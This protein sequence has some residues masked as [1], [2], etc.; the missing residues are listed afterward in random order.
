MNDKNYFLEKK[1]TSHY[2]GESKIL[3]SYVLVCSAYITWPM[4]FKPRELPA[5]FSCIVAVGVP[6]RCTIL[7]SVWDLPALKINVQRSGLIRNSCFMSLNWLCEDTGCCPEDLPRAM[8]DR[9]EWR[10]R[11]RD[12][13]ATST[14][15][16]WWIRLMKNIF[17]G[18][19]NAQL[20]PVQ[21]LNSWRYLT[22][23]ARTFKTMTIHGLL[24]FHGISTLLVRM[25]SSDTGV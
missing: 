1:I 7:H 5:L 3:I 20:T 25:F 23:V 10:E 4:L 18:K 2:E 14:I 19:V 13:R 21:W 22:R 6:T 9:E 17:A 24:A 15:W 8:N 11:V 16:W 12:I